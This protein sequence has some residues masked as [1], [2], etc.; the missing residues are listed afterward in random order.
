MSDRTPITCRLVFALPIL[1][2]NVHI[3]P[4]WRLSLKT[5]VCKGLTAKLSLYLYIVCWFGPVVVVRLDFIVKFNTSLVSLMISIVNS[6][7]PSNSWN[8]MHH[9]LSCST[10][11]YSYA[12]ERVDEW[13]PRIHIATYIPTFLLHYCVRFNADLQIYCCGLPPGHSHF[14]ILN[15][16][17]KKALWIGILR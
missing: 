14:Y 1:Q 16:I 2:C 7:R 13:T 8:R 17:E 4:E 6:N 3:L 11:S 5:P 12:Y 15:T 9:L 10:E